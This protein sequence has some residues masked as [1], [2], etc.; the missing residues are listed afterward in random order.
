[1]AQAGSLVV[2]VPGL[3]ANDRDVDGDV[4]TAVLVRNV[5][6][7]TLTLHPDGSF[8]YVPTPTYAGTDQFTYLVTDGSLDSGEVTV[9]IVV[10]EVAPGD[11]GDT[12]DEGDGGT[13][14]ETSNDE[15]EEDQEPPADNIDSRA[16]G[17]R[18]D[19]RCT[20]CWNWSRVASD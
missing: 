1:M 7:G 8:V 20:A 6:H 12:G 3:L 15:N 2:T 5:G 14:S 9:T 10:E 18:F 13:D 4:L 17:W 19:V 11:G 16:R